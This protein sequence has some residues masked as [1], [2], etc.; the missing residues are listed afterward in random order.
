MVVANLVEMPGLT[1]LNLFSQLLREE[2]INANQGAAAI[3][4]GLCSDF[5]Q[6]FALRVYGQKP[7]INSSWLA[8]LAEL[9]LSRVF[10]SMLNEPQKVD[11]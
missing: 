3:L 10:N 5:I 2:A 9:R 11:T 4:N 6:A 8:L 7:D 1:V